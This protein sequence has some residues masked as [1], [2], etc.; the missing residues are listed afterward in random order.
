MSAA[1]GGLPDLQSASAYD[2]A[3]PPGRIARYPS[4]RRDES[5][6]LVVP[7]DLAGAPEWGVEGVGGADAPPVLRDLRFRDLP[8]LLTEGDLLVLNESRVFPA[9]L[10]GKKPTG[11]ECEIL[12]LRPIEGATGR[13]PDGASSARWE[14][15]VRPGGKLKPGREVIVSEELR[16]VIE[17]GLPGGARIVRLEARGPVGEAIERF[18]R[19]PLPPYLDRDEE[20]IDRERYQTVY[21]RE[22]GSVAAPTAGL[23]FTPELLDR[24]RAAGVGIARVTLHVGP[25]TFRP[26]DTA[27][28]ADHTMHREDWEVPPEAAE[29]VAETRRRRG[30]VWAVGTTVVRTLETAAGPDGEVRPGRG[31]TDLFISPGY[32][33]RV[34]DGLVT[35]FHLPK[36]TLLVLVAAFAGYRRTMDAYRHAIDAGYRFYSY[37]DAMVIPPAAGNRA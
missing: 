1:A 13:G 21:A 17:E 9:R 29:A 26:L 19:I 4:Q 32:P 8:T 28:V 16:V 12:L 3:L 6:L 31:S 5:R 11:A 2:Y 18:G 36:S 7:R 22:A 25:G 34:V 15:F 14:A 27:D 35:N 20:P 23:H 10:H 24:V 30:R 37:G 33:F